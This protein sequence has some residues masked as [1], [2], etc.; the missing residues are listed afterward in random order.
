MLAIINATG[1]RQGVIDMIGVRPNAEEAIKRI[2]RLLGGENNQLPPPPYSVW[3]AANVLYRPG[4][5]VIYQGQPYRCLQEHRS[6]AGW[7][8]QRT[9]SLWARRLN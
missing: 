4:D 6:N 1:S 2:D 5:R 3:S 8:P 9:P 7:T